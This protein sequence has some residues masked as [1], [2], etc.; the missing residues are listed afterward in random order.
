MSTAAAQR[1]ALARSFQSLTVRVASDFG[2]FEL[3]LLTRD[4][5]VEARLVD[6]FGMTRQ[7]ALVGACMPR[8][9]AAREKLAL[10]YFNELRFEREEQTGRWHKA[11]FGD[12][13]GS[14]P[15]EPGFLLIDPQLRWVMDIARRCLQQA[16]FTA[17]LGE[18]PRLI[19]L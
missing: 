2:D 13:L 8:S 19:W 12:R 15:D 11:V 1:R 4:E 5:Q 14:W 18:Q 16:L 6:E 17:R 3:P 10:F 9:E 7:W